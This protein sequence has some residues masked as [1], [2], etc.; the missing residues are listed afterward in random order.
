MRRG[1]L[2]K[3][4]VASWCETVL[5]VHP[6]ESTWQF[7][8]I[9]QGAKTHTDLR[10]QR[11]CCSWRFEKKAESC[12]PEGNFIIVRLHVWKVDWVVLG[13][14][15]LSLRKSQDSLLVE[16]HTRDQKVVSS[17]PGR[18]GRRLFFFRVNFVC[19]VFF[20]VHSTPVLQQWGVKPRSLCQKCIHSW[21]DE[22]RVG[23]LCCCPGILWELIRKTSSPATCQGTLSHS[24][25]SS[26]SYCGLIPV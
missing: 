19:W 23:W 11:S 22:V 24:C 8:T 5:I 3:S 10:S 25:L 18:S 13:G 6:W 16:H 7:C 12:C 26:L 4:F 1:S 20:D 14:I 2:S 21:P 9:F 17:N 15:S